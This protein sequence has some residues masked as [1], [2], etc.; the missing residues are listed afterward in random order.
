MAGHYIAAVGRCSQ[1]TQVVIFVSPQGSIPYFGCPGQPL[2][3]LGVLGL[4]STQQ[5]GKG[6]G[7]ELGREWRAHG[8]VV[9]LTVQLLLIVGQK[10]RACWLGLLMAP[11]T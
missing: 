2:G 7:G 4:T 5:Q 8:R 10:E 11:F 6:L 1:G 9:R 3:R